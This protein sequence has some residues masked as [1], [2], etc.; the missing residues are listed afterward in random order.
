MFVGRWGLYRIDVFTSSIDFAREAE[1]T[2]VRHPL[3]EGAAWILSAEAIAVFKLL[4]FRT[5]DLADRERLVAI[6]SELNVAYV[7]EHRIAMMGEDDAWRPGTESWQPCAPRSDAGRV[8]HG[9]R[10]QA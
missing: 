3:G 6:R 8:V 4:F 2:R 1:A 5:K 7:R 10:G 9:S